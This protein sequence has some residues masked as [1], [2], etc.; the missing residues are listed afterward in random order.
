MRLAPVFLAPLAFAALC[1]LVLFT[2]LDRPGFTDWREARDAR[3]ARELIERRE[4]LTPLYAREPLF[5]KPVLAYAPE[6]AAA[7]LSPGE[8]GPPLA[9]RLWRAGVAAALALLVLSVGAGHFGARAGLVAAIVMLTSLALPHAVRTDGTVLL[10]TFLGWVGAAGFADALFGRPSGR[11][12]RLVVAWGALAAAF[13]CAGPM[14]ALWP[15]GGLALYAALAR[16]PGGMRAA[17]PLAGLVLVLGVALPWYGAMLERHGLAFAAR[18]PFFPYAAEARG[19]WLA[20]PL[21]AL[22]FL[23]VGLFPWIALAPEALRHA[24]TWWRRGHPRIPRDAAP[25]PGDPFERERREESAAHYFVACL[26]AACVPMALYPGPPLTAMLPALPAAAL[27]CGRLLDHLDESPERLA[28]SLTRATGMLALT[29]TVAA[30]LLA[31]MAA[32]VREVAP[33]LRL[34]AAAV[35][36]TSWA[37]FLAAFIGRHRL[38]AALIA[39]P[40]A[41]G[42]PLA[43]LV[44]LP[45]FE[46]VLN[47]RA[48]AVAMDA[49]APARAPLVLDEP[50]P[51][52]LRL[53][54]RRNLVVVRSL[55]EPLGDVRGPDS[56]VYAAFRPAHEAAV[57]RAMPGPLEFVLRTPKLVLVRIHPAR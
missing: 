33:E 1:V 28:A 10:G 55:T 48:V 19:S 37:P 11:D 34:V 17:R 22:S 38:G 42:A 43:S 52:S 46:D 21:L 29:G 31:V 32:R 41:V 9:S 56:L 45:A 44:L 47:A 2:G 3:V 6:V 39:L 16:H 15:V 5:E 12:L 36:A 53:Y 30:V 8:P 23:V 35:F 25:L 51:P 26:V 20:G 54:A 50:P 4:V 7:L 18:A 24:A 14:S 49:A 13:V 40:V 27:L 57:T